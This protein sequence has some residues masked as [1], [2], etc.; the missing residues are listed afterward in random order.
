MDL[1]LHFLDL[2]SGAS[3]RN[4]S[5]IFFPVAGTGLDLAFGV[6]CRNVTGCL[7]DLY[8]PEPKQ[9]SDFDWIRIK[10]LQNRIGSGVKRNF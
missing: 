6:Y 4:R 9:E 7:L 8:L 5:E 2:D 3:N 1:I 10:N